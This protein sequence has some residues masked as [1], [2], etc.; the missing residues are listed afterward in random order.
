M[1]SNKI[2]HLTLTRATHATKLTFKGDSGGEVT[3]ERGK[4]TITSV[5]LGA[6]LGSPLVRVIRV[7]DRHQVIA[8]AESR[9]DAVQKAVKPLPR[10]KPAKVVEE[11]PVIEAPVPVVEA[12]APVIETPAPAVEA[13]PVKVEVEEPAVSQPSEDS[14][15][16]EEP[17]PVEPVV[18]EEPKPKPKP[19]T[20][21][22]STT[23]RKKT[24]SKTTASKT[25]RSTKKSD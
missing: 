20:R 19:R 21:K 16:E 13:E 17:P 8:G 23:T 5:N 22:K 15:S 11:I 4:I 6:N 1:S 2:W 12:P 10:P 3:L 25:R 24:A 7:E 18:K 14:A 9:L